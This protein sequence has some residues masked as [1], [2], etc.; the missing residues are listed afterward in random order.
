V[1]F[2]PAVPLPTELL[3]ECARWSGAHVWSDR[4]A[5]VYASATTLGY[6]S[7]IGGEHALNVPP[8]ITLTDLYTGEPLPTAA[9]RATFSSDGPIT[10]LFALGRR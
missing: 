1:V 6:H 8:G 4:N 9:G 3:R 10:R 2:S 7:A 5:V